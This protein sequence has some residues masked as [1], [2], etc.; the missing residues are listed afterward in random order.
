VLEP[1]PWSS[2]HTAV[3]KQD[4]RDVPYRKYEQLKLRPEGFMQ[5]LTQRVGFELLAELHPGP[6]ADAPATAAQGTKARKQQQRQ[7][8]KQGMQEQQQQEQTTRQEE[9]AGAPGKQHKQ[10]QQQ[11]QGQDEEEQQQD[12]QREG[13]GKAPP[14]KPAPK[15]GFDRP[16]WVL[17]KPLGRH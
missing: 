5:Y 2:Y 3:H 11:Q 17:R 13:E 7:H 9:A 14:G 10:Q 16:V 1:Q 15:S 8:E 4:M 12:K 6:A